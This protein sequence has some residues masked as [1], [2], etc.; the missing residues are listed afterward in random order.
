M[1]HLTRRNVLIGAAAGGGLLA[2]FA[3]LPRRY[4]NPFD[5][6]GK[7]EVGY[8]AWIRV[9]SGGVVTIALPVCEMGQGISTLL[10]QIAATE[11]GAD[12]SLVSVEPAPQSPAYADPV[13]AAHWAGLWMP[14]FPG[15]ADAPGDL[16][17]ERYADRKPLLVTADGTALAAF[18]QPLR[19][20]AAGVRA[21]L[22]MAAAKQWGVR[23]EEC[24]AMDGAISH[25]GKRLPFGALAEA[26]ARLDPPSPPVLLPEP[27]REV[28]SSN[29]EG[30]R[31]RFPRLDLPAK[32]DGSFTFAGDVRVPGMV[33]AAIAHGPQGHSEL[34]HYD[35]EAAAKV[36]GLVGVVHATGWIAAAA[37]TWFAADKA[38]RAMAPT[39]R[40]AGRIV[41]TQ[42]IED[43]F[44]K[45]LRKGKAHRVESA[46]D[47]D[48]VLAKPDLTARYD[49]DPALHAAI[50]TATATARL[51]D[52]RLELWMAT[53]A[54]ERARR[55]AARIAGVSLADT[56]LYP[57]QAG[58]SFDAR[59]DT[60]VAEEVTAIA[61]ALDK[62]VQLRWSRWQESLAGFPR[63]PVA[64]ELAAAVSNDK[65]QVLGWRTRMALPASAIES[66]ARLLAGA[67]PPA[68]LRAAKGK[69]DPMA[70]AGAMPPYAI[71]ERAVDH[72]PVDIALPTAR[73]R[74]NAHG[75]GAFFTES[76]I[77]ELA[78]H[79][80][81]EPLSFR[82]GMLGDQPRLAACLQGVAKLA[83]WGG[84]GD[85]S[86][87]G[88][89]C[90]T[91]SLA[92]PEG[93]RFGHVAVV[94][95]ARRDEGGVRVDRLSAFLDIGRI[96]NVDVARQ[97]VEGAM[98][99]GLAMT[100]GGS[101]GYARGLPLAGHLSELGLPLLAD[102]PAIDV[103]FA[104]SD[105]EPF[106]PGELAV[107]PV[108]PAI[109]NALFSA[110]GLRFRRLPL[111]SEGE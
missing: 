8:N 23:W 11:M 21:V 64:A 74:S 19:E 86:G 1:R 54:P 59:L 31:P 106:D 34:S 101:T 18:E 24:R 5:Q 39:F 30:M 91:M 12:W 29:P 88:I 51:K 66:G 95:T 3:L 9:S 84:G 10:P 20:A 53:Q 43:A 107:A 61:K 48:A 63:T 4:A 80:E 36:P 102:C 76:F 92:G 28:P 57:M 65:T 13:L 37:N 89:A 79:G 50:E 49:I 96:V 67:T 35:K 27:P 46:G 78:H 38:V 17:A 109:A 82:V 108:A 104:D 73:Y 81:R 14:A 71:P 103:Q 93:E 69:A 99:F 75:Y 85:N 22:A 15:L 90:H 110:T 70:C 105:A 100:L 7:G 58:G 97:Q 60:R 40:A 94:A 16:A 42:A 111:L 68:A 32:V 45:A 44:D 47:P 56:V 83:T 62:P 77:D 41:D 55:A 33:H 72:V 25:G 52:G 98:V 2:A 87:Q 26:A 6:G